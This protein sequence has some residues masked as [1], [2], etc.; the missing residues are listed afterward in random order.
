[1]KLA[2]TLT[3][4]SIAYTTYSIS[5]K[6]SIYTSEPPNNRLSLSLTANAARLLLARR[7]GLSQYHSLEDADDTTIRILD[8]QKGIQ[9]LAFF[10][11]ENEPRPQNILVVVEGVEQPEVILRSQASYSAFTIQNA[12]S[13]FQNLR[14]VRDFLQQ[15]RHGQVHVKKRCTYDISKP[16]ISGGIDT[17]EEAYGYCHIGHVFDSFKGH[18]ESLWEMILRQL[19]KLEDLPG[20]TAVLQISPF[21]KVSKKGI[22]TQEYKEALDTLQSTLSALLKPHH[23]RIATV[24][25]MPPASKSSKPSSANPYGSYSVPNLQVRDLQSE[26]PLTVPLSASSTPTPSLPSHRVSTPGAHLNRPVSGIIPICHPSLEK[27]INDTN[28]CSG[29]GTPYQRSSEKSKNNKCFACKC[30]KTVLELK[31]GGTKTIEWG[32][33]ACQKKDVSMSFWLIA[34]FTVALVAAVSW[35]VGLLYSIGQEELPSVIG[36]GVAGPKA[37]R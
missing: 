16:S 13:P 7:L 26:E 14:L 32:G 4:A 10:A 27:L 18:P 5:P 24:M 37:Q 6:A 30:Q 35:G 12:P 29:H 1:M 2:H 17:D 34:G 28:N 15:D 36:A 33:A 9:Q 31:G 25:F 22:N 21:E 23:N 3:W 20:V 19:I 8:E 11:D